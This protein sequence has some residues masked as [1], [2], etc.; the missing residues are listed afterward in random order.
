MDKKMDYTQ[1]SS[2]EL[3]KELDWNRLTGI[4]SGNQGRRVRVMASIKAVLKARGLKA[5]VE[6]GKYVLVEG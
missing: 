3:L 2:E 5:K 4:V 6:N 1:M